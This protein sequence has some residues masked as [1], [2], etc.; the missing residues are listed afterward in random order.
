[1]DLTHKTLSFYSG[2]L[3]LQ[4][5]PEHLNHLFSP[6]DCGFGVISDS[7][8]LTS[9]SDSSGTAAKYIQNERAE[10]NL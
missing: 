5:T 1:M 8:L 9:L 4:V 3:C 7:L 6:K 2:Q 10:D